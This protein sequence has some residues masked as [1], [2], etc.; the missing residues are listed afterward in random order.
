MFSRESR[1]DTR[2]ETAR[3]TATPAAPPRFSGPMGI[4]SN[5]PSPGYSSVSPDR[6]TSILGP[7]I[8]IFGQQLILKTKGS[9]LIQ[10]HIEGD[11]HGESVT[12][13]NGAH[14]KGVITARTIAIQGGVKGELK[15]SNVILHEHSVVEAS[16]VQEKLT[17][18]EGAHFEGSVKKAKDASEVTPDLS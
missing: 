14:V 8:S 1:A 4:V 10:G 3:Q 9:L 7:D 16:I 5:N 13:D 15:G 12:V 6:P 18:A 11:V 17:I 2:A